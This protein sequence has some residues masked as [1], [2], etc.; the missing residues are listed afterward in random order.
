MFLFTG[1]IKDNIVYGKLD[2][3]DEEIIEEEEVVEEEEEIL[4]L[5]GMLGLAVYDDDESWL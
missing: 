5:D 3:T 1:T 2:A 4:L